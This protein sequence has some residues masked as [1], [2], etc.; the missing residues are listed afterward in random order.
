MAHA[1]T[2]PTNTPANA[3]SSKDASVE[4]LY[5]MM[6]LLKSDMKQLTKTVS[7]V[8]KAE[9]RRVVET[10]KDKGREL[11][12]AGED[13]YEALRSTAE[14]YGHEAGRYVREQPGTALGIAAGVGFILGFILTS[15]R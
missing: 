15:R 14:S 9:S 10:A 2:K 7:E 8:G 1:Q 4:D 12:S 3:S 6:D 5:A 13:Q 11:R